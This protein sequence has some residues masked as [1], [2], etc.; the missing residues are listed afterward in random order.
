MSNL[1]DKI[2]NMTYIEG[3]NLFRSQLKV[4]FEINEIEKS[5]LSQ[6]I[7]SEINSNHDAINGFKETKIVK[8]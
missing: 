2:F 6:H 5:K 8:F 7:G 1:D 4:F 3:R